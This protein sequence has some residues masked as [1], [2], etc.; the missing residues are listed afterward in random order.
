MNIMKHPKQQ[1]VDVTK[2]VK[3]PIQHASLP[4]VL[5]AQIREIY[6]YCKPYIPRTLEAWEIDFMRDT[7]PNKE[8]A[9]WHNIIDH[10]KRYLHLRPTADAKDVLNVLLAISMGVVNDSKDTLW[11]D[12]DKFLSIYGVHDGQHRFKP[13]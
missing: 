7:N 9:I 6:D 12:I 1:M 5:L 2:I 13:R 8:I 3:G 4:S 11:K 10:H